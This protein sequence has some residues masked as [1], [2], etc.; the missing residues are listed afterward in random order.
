MTRQVLLQTLKAS[1]WDTVKA[2]AALNV[3]RGTIYYQL[4]KYGI[5]LQA[6]LKKQ[7]L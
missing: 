2:A 3:S 5:N 1:G 7:I 6:F 4:K